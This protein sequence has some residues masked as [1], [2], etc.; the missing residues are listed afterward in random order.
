MG[1]L[2][3]PTVGGLLS[4][5]GPNAVRAREQQR[6][7]GMLPRSGGGMM[8]A[9]A[10]IIDRSPGFAAELGQGLG[11]LGK[12]LAAFGKAQKA[13]EQRAALEQSI[14]GLPEEQQRIARLN[15][16]AWAKQAAEA[17]FRQQEPLTTSNTALFDVDGKP[18]RMRLEEGIQQGL[19]EW[20]DP[21]GMKTFGSDATGYYGIMP[22]E[23]GRPKVI[24][25]TKGMGRKTAYKI[26]ETNEGVFAINSEDPS[27][28]IHIGDAV[29][30]P[31]DELANVKLEQLKSDQD[32]Q[33]VNNYED[34]SKTIRQA[35]LVLNH[36][37][38]ESGTG[39]SRAWFAPFGVS[40]PGSDTAGFDAQ[41]ETLK[42]KVFLPEVQKMQGM[43]ALSNAEGQ[44]IAAAFAALDPNMGDAEFERTLRTAISDLTAA[45]ERARRLLPEGYD[46]Q[47][48][49]DSGGSG[50]TLNIVVTPPPD[51]FVVVE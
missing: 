29:A 39:M 12:G 26:A 14:A 20:K 23:N 43:G 4:G 34:L 49:D 33:Y 7:A 21:P 37:G 9:P 47:V 31:Q 17:A 36:E 10:P 24:P 42:S 15:P 3:N 30:K 35:E 13:E 27:D 1:L 6:I 19:P 32:R 11:G 16:E 8:G 5:G 44:K 38:R 25:L 18:K 51:G 41:L 22:G 48:T 2:S 28:R 46:G 50:T 45:Q 40:I